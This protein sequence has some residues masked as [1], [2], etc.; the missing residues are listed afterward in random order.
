MFTTVLVQTW[1]VMWLKQ[2]SIYVYAILSSIKGLLQLAFFRNSLIIHGI[3]QQIVFGYIDVYFLL[4]IT[5]KYDMKTAH[6][7]VNSSIKENRLPLKVN[8]LS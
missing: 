5:I 3:I 2:L 4:L 6:K 1:D 7:I 8:S